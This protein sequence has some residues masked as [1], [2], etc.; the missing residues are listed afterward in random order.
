M[1]INDVLK[2]RIL[3][4]AI[5][6]NLI[7]NDESLKRCNVKAIDY[8]PFDI[9]NNWVWSK[10]DY[11]STYKNGFA[12]NSSMMN[13]E[14]G[15][16]YPVIKSANIGKKEVIIN[17]KTDY[18]AKP[19]EKMLDCIINKNDILMVL[20]SQSSNVEPLGVSAIYKLDTPALLNQRVLKIICNDNVDP[21]YILFAINSK[22]FHTKLS[23]KAAGLAQANLKL[24]HVLSMEIPIPP[25]EEQKRI[26][27]RI[28]E[29]YCLIDKKEKNDNEKNKLKHILKEKILD[30][31]IHGTLVD[32]DLSVKPISSKY[33]IHE[34]PF[35]LPS[36]WIWSNFDK[37]AIKISDGTHS[38]PKYIDEG[39]PFLSVKDMSDGILHFDNC[40]YISKE[41]HDTLYKRCDPKRNDL[42]IT[43]V[44][45][46]G[47]PVIVD[48]DEEFSIFVSVAQLRFNLEE[49]DLKFIRYV[50]LSKF[51]QD[52]I[53]ENT[54][55]AVNK[56]W[57]IKDIK[58]TTIPLPPLEEQKKIV[59]KIE[60]LFEL[61]EQL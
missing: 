22:W 16:G 28:E 1:I 18:V 15:I 14:D 42:L 60:S 19:N 3:E 23:N 2:E 10:I 25:L 58:K 37:M 33:A 54:R 31:A 48:T 32:N 34:E 59:E 44:G 40:K 27:D 21:N 30:S 50:V 61:I 6:G 43:K 13:N 39:V 49:L 20:S 11:I 5:T 36:N 12:F 17:S 56:N 45:T 35:V 29:L 46:T 24:D 9:P 55:G 52:I 38:T 47:V 26:V 57:V 41:E 7:K 51:V 4:V 8:K 53:S